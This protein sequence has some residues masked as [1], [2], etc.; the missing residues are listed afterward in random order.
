MKAPEEE[1]QDSPTDTAVPGVVWW[2]PGDT[3]RQQLLI[4][5]LARM[6]RHALQAQHA[7]G[8]TGSHEAAEAKGSQNG[9]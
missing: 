9:G 5:C 4:R 7:G 1:Q 2:V 8:P 3:L 6:V